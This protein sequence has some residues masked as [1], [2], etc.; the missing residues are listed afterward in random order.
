MCVI[1]CVI[2]VEHEIEMLFFMWLGNASVADKRGCVCV[3][4]AH[5][6]LVGPSAEVTVLRA[7]IHVLTQTTLLRTAESCITDHRV[8]WLPFKG[9]RNN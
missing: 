4:Q 7:V 8:N 5:G 3:C 1:N 9:A 2:Q 6:S